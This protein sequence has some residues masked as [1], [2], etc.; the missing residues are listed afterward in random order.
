M[1]LTSHS[2]CNK[3]FVDQTIM[4]GVYTTYFHF[5]FRFDPY[6]NLIMD[7]AKYVLSLYNLHV[8]G[9]VISYQKTICISSQ[10][11]PFDFLVLGFFIYSFFNMENMTFYNIFYLSFLFFLP[12][13]AAESE[14]FNSV[15]LILHSTSHNLVQT[16]SFVFK[17]FSYRQTYYF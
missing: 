3:I 12:Q 5:L 14:N 1:T 7:A 10:N 17:H 13:A 11:Q 16:P 6:Y 4:G 9:C 15:F 2:I 8:V